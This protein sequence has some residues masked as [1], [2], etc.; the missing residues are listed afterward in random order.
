VAIII[1]RRLN[2][3][4]KSTENRKKLLK[5]VRDAIKEQLPEIIKGRNATDMGKNGGSVS[6][7]K[8]SIKEPSF[9]QGK[10]GR[11]DYVLPGNER[12]VPGDVVEKPYGDGNGNGGDEA[13]DDPSSEDDL[14]INISREE[15]LNYI[16]EDLELPNLVK[17]EL[18]KVKETVKRH[19]GFQTDGSPNKLSVVR[20][21]KQS[22]L[23]RFPIAASIKAKIEELEEVLGNIDETVHP[24]IHM[25]IG[26][27]VMLDIL[28]SELFFDVKRKLEDAIVYLNKRLETI[29]TLDPIDL[30]YRQTLCEQVPSTHA[31]MVMIMDNSGSMGLHEKTIAKK[32]FFLLYQFLKRQYEEVDIVC[33]SHTGDAREMTEDEFFNTSETGGTVVSTALELL[34][35]IMNERL[36]NRTNVYVSQV[37]DGDNMDSDNPRCK[38]LLLEKILPDIQYYA[39]IQVDPYHD[40]GDEMKSSSLYIKST[41]YEKGLWKTYNT[42]ASNNPK[43]QMRRVFSDRDIFPVFK[44]LFEK[45]MAL[46]G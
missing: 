29:P 25:E 9:V 18:S 11:R 10:G 43:F 30:R 24:E 36:T 26:P 12:Y 27:G 15:F 7:S 37:S 4:G 32:F 17:K 3:S 14:I 39:Y 40:D 35:K 41:S 31:T 13:S 42:V 6:I 2:G 20:S 23:R 45:K 44:Q 16:F 5:R 46:K 33:I 8:K 21:F 1:D 19:A 34:T 28:P 22:L 38:E